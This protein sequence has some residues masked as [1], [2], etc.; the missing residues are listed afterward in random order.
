MIGW[1]LFVLSLSLNI[2]GIWYIREL[3]VRFR[4]VEANSSDLWAA[5]DEYS[6]HL[7]KVYDLET[8]YGDSTLSGL[9]SHTRDLKEDLQVYREL[10]SLEDSVDLQRNINNNDEDNQD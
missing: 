5:V 8:Y 10:F 4:F 9:L 3:M 7:Q 1:I 2:L 6:D